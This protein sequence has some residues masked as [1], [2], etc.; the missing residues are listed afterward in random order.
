MVFT[1]TV[2][3][4]VPKAEA[5]CELPIHPAD[6]IILHQ[7]RWNGTRQ[8]FSEDSGQ[9]EYARKQ[10]KPLSASQG[11]L[12][13]MVTNNE[14]EALYRRIRVLPYQG[15]VIEGY[16]A[17]GKKLRLFVQYVDRNQ[18]AEMD[19]DA[20]AEDTEAVVEEFEEMLKDGISPS[21]H[22]AIRSIRNSTWVQRQYN[23]PENLLDT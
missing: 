14:D 23:S 12:E 13:Y 5:F 3:V 18:E 6:P 22:V 7:S 16:I 2:A 10:T 19:L 21:S 20:L 11:A 4:S 8:P 9:R 15:D 1:E 17:A